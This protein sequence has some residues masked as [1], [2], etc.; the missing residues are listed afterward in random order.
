[1]ITQ[2]QKKRLKEIIGS[3]CLL[4]LSRYFN[5]CEIF[6]REGDPYSQVFISGVLNGRLANPTIEAGIWRFAEHLKIVR[7]ADEERKAEILKPIKLS[8]NE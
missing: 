4:Q 3:K 5:E 6:N 8:E 2:E 1:M 7:Q